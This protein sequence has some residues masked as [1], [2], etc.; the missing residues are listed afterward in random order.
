MNVCIVCPFWTYSKRIKRS[1]KYMLSKLLIERGHQVYIITTRRP[2]MPKIKKLD[3]ITIYHVNAIIPPNLNYPLVNIAEL[4]DII[5]HVIKTYR[6]EIL[7]FWN[8]EFPTTWPAFIFRSMPKLLTIV[9]VPGINWFYGQWMI[10]S[11]AKLYTFGI[12]RI[13]LMSFQKIVVFGR[14]I[15][16][17]LVR[18]GVPRERIVVIPYGTNERELVVLGDK[19]DI[20]SKWG[21]RHG[22][23]LILFVGR[24]AP[25][26]GITYFLKAAEALSKK[27]PNTRFLI[28]GDGPLRKLVEMACRAN[29]AITYLGYRDDVPELMKA[30]DIFVLPS[31]SEGLPLVLL[32]AGYMGLPVIA[33]NVGAVPDIITDGRTGLLVN[34]G[35]LRQLIRAISLLIEYE[36]LRK[37]LGI[38]LKKHIETYCRW[39][40]VVDEYEKLYE[41][42]LEKKAKSHL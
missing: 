7:H 15:L 29:P 38:N 28:V 25:V 35:S 1:E 41:R 14:P 34:R 30:S 24:L 42:I 27:Y 16:H 39:D 36:D 37:K 11:I 31:I 20:R 23:L 12:G 17:H 18:L 9:G 4:V 10:D 33:T 21:F 40:K 2:G 6:I 3:D 22:E 5:R 19:Y 13:L 8:F 32:E 26:K